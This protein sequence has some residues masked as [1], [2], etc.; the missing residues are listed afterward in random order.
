VSEDQALQRLS[1]ILAQPQFQYGLSLSWWDQF[2]LWMLSRAFDL[3]AWIAQNLD[4]V[5]RGRTGVI[6]IVVLGVAVGV[7]VAI[8]L[9]LV[10]SIRLAVRGEATLRAAS[11]AERRERSDRLWLDAQEAARRGEWATAVRLAYLSAL[12]VLD[13]QS[14]LHV[15]SGLTNREHALRLQ[16]QHPDLGAIF[17]DL[18]Q[19]YD[20][21]RYGHVP[22]TAELF[23]EVSAL[24]ARA[25]G[26]SLAGAPA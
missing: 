14:L 19:R 13:E 11:M 17:A 18:V 21:V 3:I 4:T 25:R 12:Y 23:G 20:R 24:V 2:K 5:V 10:R 8:T 1:A 7:L 26:T 9:Y 6:G 16:R 22:V 15:E